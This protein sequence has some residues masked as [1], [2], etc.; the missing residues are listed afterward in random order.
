MPSPVEQKVVER[1][2]RR[3]LQTKGE[4]GGE[5]GRGEGGGRGGGGETCKTP[6]GNTTTLE[7]WWPRD[8]HYSVDGN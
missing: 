4:G 6:E 3:H 7:H 2:G 1:V 5:R 8:K